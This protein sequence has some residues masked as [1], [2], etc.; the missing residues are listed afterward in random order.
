MGRKGLTDEIGGERGVGVG[1]DPRL[2]EDGVWEAT[3]VS[4]A[5]LTII[6]KMLVFFFRAVSYRFS[7]KGP[8]A[9]CWRVE[10]IPLLPIS[11]FFPV[12]KQ[13]F[14]PKKKSSYIDARNAQDVHIEPVFVRGRILQQVSVRQ[15]HGV[16]V[17]FG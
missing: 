7:S 13:H 2:V 17:P 9:A 15:L 8:S 5:V 1:L 12:R 6:F 11:S 10:S 3:G 14:H 4:A 16:A